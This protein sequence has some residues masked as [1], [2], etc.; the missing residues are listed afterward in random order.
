MAW[1]TA[2]FMLLPCLARAVSIGDAVLHSGLGEPLR[3]EVGLLLAQGE[4]VDEAC[5]SLAAPDPRDEDASGYLTKAKLTLVTV[6]EQRYIAISSQTLLN[7]AFVKM[8][9]KV[10]CPGVG[11]VIKT[12]TILPDL[13]IFAVTPETAV[14]KPVVATVSAPAVLQEIAPPV[15]LPQ[16]APAKTE[17]PA[18]RHAARA[19]THRTGKAAGSGQSDR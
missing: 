11:T 1:V 5:L 6:G 17:R 18:S 10:K 16:A 8:R 14:T 4:R 15:E 13:D 12:L 19:P 7:E 9:L 2:F 3:A